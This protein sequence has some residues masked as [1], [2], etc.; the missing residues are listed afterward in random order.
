MADRATAGLK[1]HRETV[2]R[3]WVDYNGHM[4]VAY[5]VLVFDHGTD[6]VLDRLGTGRAYCET[7]GRSLFVVES[8]LT[9]EAEA[10]AGDAL[11]VDSRVLGCD[12]KRLHLFHAM[13]RDKDGR[14]AAT[15][16]LLLV[17]VD[18]GARRASPFPD[19]VRARTEALLAAQ[20]AKPPPQAG[21][22]IALSARRVGRR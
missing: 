12:D 10:V 4:N 1:P 22:A 13:H 3:E 14:L 19:D 2:R 8:H 17:H 6:V 18:L 5:Y 7:T 11:R 21:R 16:E 9:Y 20:S 15:N